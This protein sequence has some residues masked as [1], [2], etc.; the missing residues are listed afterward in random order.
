MQFGWFVWMNLKYEAKFNREPLRGIKWDFG[1]LNLIILQDCILASIFQHFIF[2]PGEGARNGSYFFRFG[3]AAPFS[4]KKN[5]NFCHPY[6]VSFN[7][8]IFFQRVVYMF[9]RIWVL[10]RFYPALILIN[11]LFWLHFFSSLFLPRGRGHEMIKILAR[12]PLN[13]L[14]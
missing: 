13:I 10:K 7:C 6:L 1:K 12:N 14:L 5:L 11:D 3:A 4:L 9:V 2:I 8:L